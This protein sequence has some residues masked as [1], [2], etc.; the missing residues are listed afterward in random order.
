MLWTP[1]LGS[2]NVVG[3]SGTKKPLHRSLEVQPSLI[4]IETDTSESCVAAFSFIHS[5]AP[6]FVSL[7]SVS[8]VQDL[9]SHEVSKKEE[10]KHRA[11]STWNLQMKAI[12]PEAKTDLNEPRLCWSTGNTSR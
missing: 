7:F 8:L 11:I 3:L 2:Q 4:S 9:S 6:L 1:R 10:A 12:K 5:F